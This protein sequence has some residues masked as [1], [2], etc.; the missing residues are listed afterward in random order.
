MQAAA[1]LELMNFGTNA[2]VALPD[3][4]FL[5]DNSDDYLL[6]STAKGIGRFGPVASNALARLNQI[7]T[8]KDPFVRR[9]AALAIWNIDV[10]RPSPANILLE[11]MGGAPSQERVYSANELRKFDP[12][13]TAVVIQNLIDLVESPPA[14]VSGR[15]NLGPR[16]QAMDALAEIGAEAQ[17]A[18]PILLDAQTEEFLAFG[19]LMDRENEISRQRAKAA[20][21]KIQRALPSKAQP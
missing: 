3:L 10:R 20:Y 21:D 6:G 4:N 5:L 19:K 9:C 16:W 17:A 12:S 8:N 13:Y 11:N 2:F 7:L 15:P 18:L 1:A 14:S